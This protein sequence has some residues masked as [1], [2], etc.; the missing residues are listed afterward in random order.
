MPTTEIASNTEA[1]ASTSLIRWPTVFQSIDDDVSIDD[2]E[3]RSHD[4]SLR[5]HMVAGSFAGL[6]EHVAIFPLDTIRTHVQSSSKNVSSSS[7]SSIETTIDLVSKR[8]AAFLWRGSMTLAWAVV[9]AH[10]ALFSMYENIMNI[11]LPGRHFHFP[12]ET[13][14][15]EECNAYSGQR[16]AFVGFIAGSASGLVHDL[17]MV[18]AETIKQRL[19]LGYYKNALHAINRMAL[20]G[21]HSFYRSLPITLAMSLP[22]SSLMMA[23][24]ETIRYY[25][26]PTGTYSLTS[27]LLAG[28]ASGSFAAAATTPL[29]VIRTRLNTQGLER[30]KTSTGELG[31]APRHF[32]V[33][34]HGFFEAYTSIA[35]TQGLKGFFRGAGLRVL[36]L[37]PSCALSWGAYESAKHI[38]STINL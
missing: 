3:E 34:Y 31:A 16:V 18:P 24:N 29:D 27:F 36:Q 25:I 26:N 5:V 8:G 4:T 23:C 13:H 35:R 19:Q 6:V 32:K 28:A 21:G 7:L 9:P 22:Y 37:G 20:N 14:C 11:G 17:I 33:K 10:A 15:K 12:V 2:W 38:C 1:Q 30:A